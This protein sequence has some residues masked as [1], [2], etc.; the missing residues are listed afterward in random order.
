MTP[1]VY[2]RLNRRGHWPSC[3]ERIWLDV[4]RGQLSVE[5]N[6][7]ITWDILQAIKNHYWSRQ[8]CAIEIYPPAD[9]VVNNAPMRHLWLLGRDEWWPDLGH[10]G[11]IA[12]ASLRSRFEAAGRPG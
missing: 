5:H 9:R 3:V 4:E 10:E 1:P 8:A 2:I 6:G 7:R 12:P 11:E